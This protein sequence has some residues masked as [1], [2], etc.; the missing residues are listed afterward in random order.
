M[1]F[2]FAKALVRQDRRL[3]TRLHLRCSRRVS[4]SRTSYALTRFWRSV[5]ILSRLSSLFSRRRRVW[6]RW[7][8]SLGLHTPLL[9]P[10]SHNSDTCFR[11]N[12]RPRSPIT[13]PRFGSEAFISNAKPLSRSF[14]SSYC[15]YYTMSA[16]L[17]QMVVQIQSDL[18]YGRHCIKAGEAHQ[19]VC[20]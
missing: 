14:I 15:N 5:F 7:I 17:L 6:G 12:N 2:H 20:R 16:P 9:T 18:S 10:L 8:L 13:N 1:V 4:H 11:S 19:V 3:T